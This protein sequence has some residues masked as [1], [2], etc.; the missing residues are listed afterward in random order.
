[1]GIGEAAIPG[2]PRNLRRK[3]TGYSRKPKKKKSREDVKEPG[4]G[5]IRIGGR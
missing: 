1:M 4:P 5:I 2:P 3:R